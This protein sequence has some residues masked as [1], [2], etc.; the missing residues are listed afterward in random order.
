MMMME[1]IPM[2]DTRKR[3]DY[4]TEPH[5]HDPISGLSF[6]AYLVGAYTRGYDWAPEKPI[7]RALNPIHYQAR[8]SK[9]KPSGKVGM[10]HEFMAWLDGHTKVFPAVSHAQVS[11]AITR[12]RARDPL[13]L[14]AL[15][16]RQ[17]PDGRNKP[18]PGAWCMDKAITYSTLRRWFV[19]SVVLVVEEL[20]R[21]LNERYSAGT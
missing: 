9:G 18:S 2:T 13:R 11:Q 6:V 20:E 7:G 17:Q 4:R 3:S 10:R 15:D 14:Q 16:F 8:T 12:A 1:A 21:D 5:D 19:R